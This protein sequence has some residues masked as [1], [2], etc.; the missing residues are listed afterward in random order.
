MKHGD[1]SDTNDI[2]TVYYNS[3]DSSDSGDTSGSTE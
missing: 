2:T 1:S 3:G